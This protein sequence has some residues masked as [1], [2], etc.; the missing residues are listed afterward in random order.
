MP[1]D[2]LTPLQSSIPGRYQLT[3][4][5]RARYIEGWQDGV[6]GR[7]HA[8][9]DE[10]AADAFKRRNGAVQLRA[11]SA[12]YQAGIDARTGDAG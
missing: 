10:S 12:G 2:D 5:L 8:H 7:K 11:Y 4:A 1:A 9:I 6:R 3:P